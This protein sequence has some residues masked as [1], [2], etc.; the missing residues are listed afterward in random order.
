MKMNRII[1]FLGIL[2]LTLSTNFF[3]K[4]YCGY[5]ER[6]DHLLENTSTVEKKPLAATS[7]RHIILEYEHDNFPSL[8]GTWLLTKTTLKR[9]TNPVLQK[10][11]GVL[12]CN[13][14]LPFE[15][16]DIISKEVVISSQGVDHFVVNAKYPATSDVFFDPNLNKEIKYQNFGFKALI[17]PIDLTYAYTLKLN[18]HLENPALSRQL[19]LNGRLKYELISPVKIIAKGYE[20][21]P[22]PECDG[23]ILDEV[24]FTLIKAQIVTTQVARS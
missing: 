9:K 2:L 3:L 21:E 15:K 24:E 8:D 11:H 4:A 22:T 7:P 20:A 6:Y 10:P 14:R 5:A 19:W 1:K 18:N 17:D 16:R 13:S 23:Y 12:L